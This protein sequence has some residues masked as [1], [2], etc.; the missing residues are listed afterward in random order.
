[1]TNFKVMSWNVE[2]LFQPGDEVSEGKAMPASLYTA[3]LEYLAKVVS[4]VSPDVLALQE[5]GGDDNAV[6]RSLA[7]LSERLGNDYPH[8]AISSYPDGRSIRVAFLSKLPLMAHRDIVNFAE[9]ELSAVA[10]WASKPFVTRLGRGALLIQVEPASGI[11]IRLVTLH[12]KSKLITYLPKDGKTRFSP[13]DENERAIGA[14]L[15]LLRRTAEAAAVRIALNDLMLADEGIHTVV[16]GDLNDVPKAATSQLLVGPEEKDVTSED[17]G[18]AARLHNLMAALPGRGGMENDRWFLP[19][20]ERFTRIY[21]G[22]GE[23]IDHIYVSKG[24]LGES[25]E[26]KTDRWRLQEVR[27]LVGGIQGESVGND[28]GE[29]VGKERP[30]HAPIYA[31]F[32]L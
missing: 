7:D 22:Q 31:S 12:L 16:L 17:R 15:A 30:D 27:S 25:A 5:L 23:L 3:K 6:G 14:G 1:M 28:V 8:T 11:R 26:L 2:N 32:E 19:E 10:S 4:E 13:S 9:G 24:L 18:D 29:R 21:Q 20:G